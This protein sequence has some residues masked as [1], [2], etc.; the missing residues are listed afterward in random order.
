MKVFWCL[1]LVIFILASLI[2]GTEVNQKELAIKQL[3]DLLD[4]GHDDLMAESI[5]RALVV[6]ED[7]SEEAWFFD[8]LGI[9]EA[10]GEY[11]SLGSVKQFMKLSDHD[12]EDTEQLYKF[13]QI[14][15]PHR[16]IALCKDDLPGLCRILIEELTMQIETFIQQYH[17]QKSPKNRK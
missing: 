3:Q 11:N 17:Q 1:S 6:L 2:S 5:N 16:M 15:I 9:N 8:Q 7:G 4:A 13:S 10:I 14:M 12:F